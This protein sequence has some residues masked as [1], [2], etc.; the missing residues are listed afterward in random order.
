MG[1]RSIINYAGIIRKLNLHDTSMDMGNINKS[2]LTCKHEPGSVA[3]EFGAVRKVSWTI[4]PF[5]VRPFVVIAKIFPMTLGSGK[6]LFADGTI[7]AA[8]KVTESTVTS[9]GV[10]IVKYEHAG[11]VPTG[12]L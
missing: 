6:R 4:C 1:M 8:F 11:A 10:I 9:K 7:P 12:S 2:F 5:P 3:T